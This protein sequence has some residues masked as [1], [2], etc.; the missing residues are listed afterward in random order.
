MSSSLPAELEDRLLEWI[1]EAERSG[2][3]HLSSGYQG[4]VLFYEQDGIRLAIKIPSYSGIFR[5]IT[6]RMLRHEARAYEYLAGLEG[7]PRSYGII[8]RRYLVLEYIQGENLREA[9]LTDSADFYGRLLGLI[10]RMHARG[11]AHADLKRRDNI[12]VGAD[13]R[14][15]LLDFGVACV[16]R[17]GTH[18]LNHW[19]FNLARQFDLNAWVKHK[20]HR[21]LEQASASDRRYLRR[22]WIERV[23]SVLKGAWQDVLKRFRRH[24]G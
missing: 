17:R 10:R 23:A 6:I 5:W 3:H 24:Q 2:G 21:R 8:G 11:V 1:P 19:L 20:Y 15:W 13:N 16:R 14:P 22:T 12:M 18:P 7:V 4:R 9:T